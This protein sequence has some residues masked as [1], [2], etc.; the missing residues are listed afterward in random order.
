MVLLA[1]IRIVA[2]EERMPLESF[3]FSEISVNTDDEN[4]FSDSLN[5]STLECE[6]LTLNTTK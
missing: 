4:H 6:F 1:L 3:Y 5:T 2:G